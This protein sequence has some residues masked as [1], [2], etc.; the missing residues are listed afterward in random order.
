MLA[1]VL[2]RS[3]YSQYRIWAAIRRLTISGHARLAGD[4][5]WDED[6]LSAAQALA[7]PGGSWVIAF[8]S[9][10]GV[11]VADIGGNTCRNCELPLSLVM[12]LM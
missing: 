1:L 4:T 7:Q 10:L 12:R 5:S 9:G 11:D 6:D 3:V 2:K 8:D